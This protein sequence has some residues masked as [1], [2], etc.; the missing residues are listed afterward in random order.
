M[1]CINKLAEIKLVLH[2]Y[3][4][5]LFLK[6]TYLHTV[7]YAHNSTLSELS[8]EFGIHL[9]NKPF[10]SLFVLF[11]KPGTEKVKQMTQFMRT[12]RHR[13]R[14]VVASFYIFLVLSRS[15]RQLRNFDFLLLNGLLLNIE[16]ASLFKKLQLV[17]NGLKVIARLV[18]IEE[19]IGFCLWY[20]VSRRWLLFLR[21]FEYETEA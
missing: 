14:S 4:L 1:H 10:H 3:Q 17:A 13:L 7:L 19:L 2:S 20:C 21:I 12:Q 11:D 15:A 16:R 18:K 6:F 9:T 8:R 5:I